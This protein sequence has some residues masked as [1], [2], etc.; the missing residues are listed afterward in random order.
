MAVEGK[1]DT[2]KIQ[3]NLLKRLGKGYQVQ[4]GFKGSTK[5]GNKTVSL[6]QIALWNFYG[7]KLIVSR[8]PLLKTNLKGIEKVKGLGSALLNT[9]EKKPITAFEKFIRSRIQK[10]FYANYPPNRPSTIR[11]KGFNQPLIWTGRLK[12]S[13]VVSLQ[14]KKR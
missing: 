2:S 1:L 12:K 3:K 5:V 10:A 9:G 13:V 14:R 7:T 8:N 6:K 11:R 4:V